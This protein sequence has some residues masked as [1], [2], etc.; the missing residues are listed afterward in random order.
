[1]SRPMLRLN[2]NPNHSHKTKIMKI[3]ATSF[4]AGV[5]SLMLLNST[6]QAQSNVVKG[7]IDIRY[8]T[9]TQ[10]GKEGIS[11]KYTL[12]LN[13]CDSAIFRGSVDA[14]P[15]VKGTF[16]DQMGLLT[17]ALETDVVNP[18]NPAQTRNVGK[19]YGTAPVDANNVYRFESG[20]VQ[21]SV[22]PLGSAKGFDSKF[23][24]LALGKPPVKT[25]FLEKAKSAMKV[26]KVVNGKT[27]VITVNKYDIME[28]Q[29]IQLGA[30]PVQLYGEVTVSGRMV[31]DYARSAW[32]VQNMT[33]NYF[34]DN[35]LVRDSITGNIRWT[36]APNRKTSGEGQYEFD[37]R[38]NEPPVNEA[39]LFD[40][41]VKDESSFFETDNTIP[42]LTGTMKYKDTMSGDSVTASTVQ[43]S[44]AGNQLNKQ[45][46]MYLSKLFLLTAIV[47][48]NA[49]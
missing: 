29:N 11:D 42:S 5:A 1:M 49:E 17:Y 45:Q 22:F 33:A 30:G 48:L 2:S 3:L 35:K 6:A 44:L 36:E 37:I 12:N 18:K 20:T 27:V 8:N 31:Y 16:S 15:F 24:G 19:L 13:V 9:R 25:G 43:V 14:R 46:L 23:K 32:Y 40:T 10:P 26:G 39:A 34:V 4:L 28:F 21:V 38:I 47:P 41:S 7:T